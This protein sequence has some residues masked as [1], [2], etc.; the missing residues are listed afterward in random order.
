[1]SKNYANYIL[2]TSV[3]KEVKSNQFEVNEHA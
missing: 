3:Q 1:M 2:N